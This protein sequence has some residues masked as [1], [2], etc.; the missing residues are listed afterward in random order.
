MTIM[1]SVRLLLL[2]L[3]LRAAAVGGTVYPPNTGL[4][5]TSS[6]YTNAQN[7]TVFALVVCAS[8]II[9]THDEKIE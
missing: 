1:L 5:S 2:A 9:T 6:P 3:A 8:L 4:N 7:A